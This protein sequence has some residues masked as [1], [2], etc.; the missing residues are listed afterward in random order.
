MVKAAYRKLLLN[1][2]W[3]SLVVILLTGLFLYR[4]VASMDVS[5]ETIDMV[6]WIS[7]GAAGLT[8]LLVI[9]QMIWG[10][11]QIRKLQRDLDRLPVF[12]RERLEHDFQTGDQ[13]G[14][15]YFTSSH[16]FVLQVRPGSRQGIACIPYEEIQEV[17]IRPNMQANTMLEILRTSGQ[18]SHDVFEAAGVDAGTIAKINDKILALREQMDSPRPVPEEQKK[19]EDQ[20]RRAVERGKVWD[21]GIFHIVLAGGMLMLF[22]YSIV[23]AENGWSQVTDY[24][25]LSPEKMGSLLFWP[26]L[27]FYLVLYGGSLLLLVSIFLFMRK[28][29]GKKEGETVEWKSRW[30]AAVFTVIVVLFMFFVGMVY[31]ADV[32]SWAKLKLGF[33]LMTG[34]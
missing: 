23:L 11:V 29:L 17:R 8:I 1:K 6:F 3:L 21:T 28:R 18:P 12:A 27:L 7:A 30:R 34:L 26:N 14:D 9:Y 32:D 24:A 2:I 25:A 4:Y 22:C 19:A 33:Y 20:R 10:L 13:M 31:S 15:L 5:E 16:L